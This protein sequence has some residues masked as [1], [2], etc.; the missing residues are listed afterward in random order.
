LFLQIYHVTGLEVIDADADA[1]A[2]ADTA[3]AETGGPPYRA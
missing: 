1:D 3:M 2:D